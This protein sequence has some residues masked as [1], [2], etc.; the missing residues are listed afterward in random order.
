MKLDLLTKLRAQNPIVLNASNLVT[1][2]DVAN[3]L[4]AIGASPIMSREVDEADEMVQ[5][6]ESVAI[7]LGTLTKNQIVQI[8]RTGQLAAQAK[9]PVV[10]DPVAA[11]A[12]NYQLNIALE[13][14]RNFKVNIIRGNAGEIAALGGFD[15]QAKGIDA[16]SG[17]GN[18]DEI[19]LKTAAKFNCVVIASGATDTIS[20]GKRVAHVYNG[21]PLFQAHVGS[22]DM[23]TGIAA[24]FAA[25]DD[26][27]FEAAQT[28]ALVFS[29]TGEL[30]VKEHPDVGPGLF[31]VY[32]MDYLAKTKVEEIEQIA[33]FD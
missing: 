33:K 10:I 21:S 11:G 9:K 28:A 2:Q 1:I 24:A 16:G 18:I 6:A 15:W 26:D 25:V 17:T 19:T 29:T 20:D 4:N 7:N 22:G 27:Y 30:L 13:M 5:I 23:L 14:L 12:V 8:K 31:G 32:L 3:S